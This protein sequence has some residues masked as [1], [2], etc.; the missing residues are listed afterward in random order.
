M[1]VR[2]ADRIAGSWMRLSRSPSGPS[3]MVYSTW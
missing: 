1:E 2:I 3:P